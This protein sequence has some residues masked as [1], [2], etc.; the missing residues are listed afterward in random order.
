MPEKT[1]DMINSKQLFT[2]FLVIAT[3]IS[4][5]QITD[6]HWLDIKRNDIGIIT[7]WKI[8]Y[9]SLEQK[10]DSTI[11]RQLIYNKHGDLTEKR[12]NYSKDLSTWHT[13]QYKYNKSR[14]ITS[15]TNLNPGIIEGIH[16]KERR[17]EGYSKCETYNIKEQII[18]T[19]F[20]SESGQLYLTW[21]FTYNSDNLLAEKKIF[22][23]QT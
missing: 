8:N 4:F 15:V 11:H 21:L 7:E 14:E 20:T 6:F 9:D 1:I 10:I 22:P 19:E 16:I 13:I 3:Q 2:L 5:G 12:T 23:V 17:V 18:K